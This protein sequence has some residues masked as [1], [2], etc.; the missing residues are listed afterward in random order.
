MT[1]LGITHAKYAVKKYYNA[2]MNAL[3]FRDY[4]FIVHIF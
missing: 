1:W 2:Y 4:D 3:K